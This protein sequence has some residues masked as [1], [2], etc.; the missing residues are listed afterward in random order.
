[1]NGMRIA[2]T[3]DMKL[4]VERTRSDKTPVRAQTEADR[5]RQF[6]A[7]SHRSFHG[8]EEIASALQEKDPR[9]PRS[10]DRAGRRHAVTTHRLIMKTLAGF[11]RAVAE[12]LKKRPE[13]PWG[14]KAERRPLHF[15]SLVRSRI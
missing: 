5:S 6:S 7:S 4:N 2:R 13:T 1:M 10:A 14:S 3:Y 15:R 11:S 12:M 9:A 8:E